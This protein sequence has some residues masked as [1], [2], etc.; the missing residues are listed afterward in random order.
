MRAT[1]K[2]A[3]ADRL[4]MGMPVSMP[5][6]QG[7]SQIV[8][9]ATLKR[10]KRAVALWFLRAGTHRTRVRVARIRRRGGPRDYRREL[11]SADRAAH[12]RDG[13]RRFI[14]R[15]LRRRRHV[16]RAL[17]HRVRNSGRWGGLGGDAGLGVLSAGRSGAVESTQEHIE[18]DGC[19][20]VRD[21][22]GVHLPESFHCC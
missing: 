16:L 9:T 20:Q 19:D 11:C 21:G 12:H 13:R 14:F 1:P 18:P 15:L 10:S 6:K 5:Q 7:T 22:N 3:L 2:A 8:H 17:R 4:I